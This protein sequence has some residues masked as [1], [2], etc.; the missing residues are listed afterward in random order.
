MVEKGSGRKLDI[1]YR[2]FGD[3]KVK[4]FKVI[5]NCQKKLCTFVKIV[6]LLYNQLFDNHY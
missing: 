6:I 2:Y 1:V 5:G 3:L 4:K